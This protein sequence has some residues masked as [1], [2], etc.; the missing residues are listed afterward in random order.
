MHS[1]KVIPKLITIKI[2]VQLQIPAYV[3]CT[4]VVIFIFH[5]NNHVAVA[6]IRKEQ[7]FHQFTSTK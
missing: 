1:A 3:C 5:L 6:L 4:R 2:P 7:I